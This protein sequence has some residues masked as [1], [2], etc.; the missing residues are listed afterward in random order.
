MCIVCVCYCMFP[1]VCVSVCHLCAGTQRSQK[2]VFVPLELQVVVSCSV[3]VLGT[4][5][6]SCGVAAIAFNCFPSFQVNQNGAVI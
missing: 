4:N 5:L 6:R 1:C 3:W 2:R